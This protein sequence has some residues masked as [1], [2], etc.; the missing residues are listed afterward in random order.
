VLADRSH[1]PARICFVDW[2][3]A[4]IGC[5]LLDLV[6]LKHGL[7]AAH[8]RAMREAYLAEVEGT[9]LLPSS[10]QELHRLFVAC[11]LHHT[12]YRLAHLDRWRLPP[13]RAAEWVAEARELIREF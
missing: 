12:L 6:H 1:R 4:G 13:V 10:R 11:E 8:D 5:G 7:D 3:L 9:G 2:E